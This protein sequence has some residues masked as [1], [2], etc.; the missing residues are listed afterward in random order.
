MKKD[1]FISF[2]GLPVAKNLLRPES[3]QLRKLIS[4]LHN[5]NSVSFTYIQVL[6]PK[7]QPHETHPTEA[8]R[9]LPIRSQLQKH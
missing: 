4:N 8:S 9:H 5:K 7:T 3:T 1:F 6:A 2:R